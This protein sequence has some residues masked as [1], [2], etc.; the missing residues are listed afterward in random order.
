[1]TH[2][3]THKIEGHQPRSC[4]DECEGEVGGNNVGTGKKGDLLP[5]TSRKLVKDLVRHSSMILF[6]SSTKIIPLSCLA[7]VTL[8]GGGCADG[9]RVVVRAWHICR[10]FV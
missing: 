5:T 1:M 7:I 8:R 10:G 9:V 3:C 4:R 6:E 2:A